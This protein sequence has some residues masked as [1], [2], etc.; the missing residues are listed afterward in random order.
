[1]LTYAAT[2]LTNNPGVSFPLLIIVPEGP[3]EKQR[4]RICAEI[5]ARAMLGVERAEEE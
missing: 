4:V 3:N 5:T 2:V 1:M